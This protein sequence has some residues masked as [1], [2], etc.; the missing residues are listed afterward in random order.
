MTGISGRNRGPGGIYDQ[1]TE[2]TRYL[3]SASVVSSPRRGQNLA[4]KCLS[5]ASLDGCQPQGPDQTRTKHLP[6]L[7]KVRCALWANR[8]WTSLGREKDEDR[9]GAVEGDRDAP[10][11]RMR[12]SKAATQ[13][14]DSQ[15]EERSG[16]TGRAG[17]A[18][19]RQG[20]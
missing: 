12:E 6:D 11:M 13:G 14:G 16:L 3:C 4:R 9:L 7:A 5:W 20:R 8:C 1:G 10:K 18:W 19:L 17:T 2:E 15:R